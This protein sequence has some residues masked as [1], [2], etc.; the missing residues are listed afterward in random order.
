MEIIHISDGDYTHYEELLLERD[1]L[2]Q[3]AEQ[4]R[5]AYIREFGKLNTDLFKEKIDSIALKKSIAFCQTARA[6]ARL[7]TRKNWSTIWISIWPAT[8]KP[9]M[10][11]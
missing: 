6:G 1:R 11:S 3:E 7:R 2:E 5:M 10:H 4:Y 9:W 8:G